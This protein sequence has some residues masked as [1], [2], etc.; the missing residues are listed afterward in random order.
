M[1]KFKLDKKLANDCFFID[2]LHLSQL[3]LMN[4]S[5][6][7]WLIL[8]PR[9]NNV[10]EIIDLAF[11]EQQILLKEINLISHII[12]ND[13]TYHK[14]NIAALGNVVKQLHIHIIGR[15]ENDVSYPK[16]I[17]GNAPTKPYTADKSQQIIDSI[18]KLLNQQIKQNGQ[19]YFN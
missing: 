13:F 5:N 14:L 12:K 17:W 4:D 2:N 10:T 18:K 1:N 9:K 16:P 8:V 3:L 7:L 19:G 15:Q 6:Y 11:S